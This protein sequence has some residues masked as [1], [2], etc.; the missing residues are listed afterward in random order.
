MRRA[1]DLI[2][3]ESD[4]ARTSAEKIVTKI[5]KTSVQFMNKSKVKRSTPLLPWFYHF[6]FVSIFFIL[7]I[8]VTAFSVSFCTT[9]CHGL[10]F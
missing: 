5:W 8:F 6:Y 7:K 4:G 1:N 9:V 3:E 10:I 2:P